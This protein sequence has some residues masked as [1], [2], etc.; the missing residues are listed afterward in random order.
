MKNH[1]LNP[2][3]PTKDETC[4]HGAN[5]LIPGEYRILVRI[6]EQSYHTIRK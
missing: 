2:E 1:T 4:L 5:M 6:S 3:E